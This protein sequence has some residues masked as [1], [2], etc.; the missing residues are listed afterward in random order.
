[1]SDF[2]K[3]DGYLKRQVSRWRAQLESYAEHEGWPGADSIPGVERVGEWLDMNRPAKFRPGI[4]HG[5]FHLSNV[6]FC[7]DSPELAAVVDWELTTIG[8]PLLDLGWLLATWPDPDEPGGVVSVTPWD[9]F[10]EPDELIRHYAA[11]SDRDL[12]AIGWYGVLAC[13]KLGLILEGTYARACAG[14]APAETGERL[15]AQTL[16]LLGRALRW[17]DGGVPG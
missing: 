11:R 2:G 4:I 8:D 5:D 14:K 6:M 1:L 9:G 16:R 17:I 10:P 7:Y 13:Y 12:S 15:H 3:P